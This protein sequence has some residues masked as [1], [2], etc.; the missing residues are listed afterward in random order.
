VGRGFQQKANAAARDLDFRIDKAG[1][2]QARLLQQTVR[3][4]AE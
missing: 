4:E 2:I 1:S 3:V